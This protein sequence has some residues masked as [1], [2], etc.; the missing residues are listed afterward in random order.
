MSLNKE[1]RS[2]RIS[3]LLLKNQNGYA[4]NL[5]CFKVDPLLSKRITQKVGINFSQLG[6]KLFN[7]SA[8]L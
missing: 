7:I 8:Q 5:I 6:P 1:M 4:L 2:Q 3:L